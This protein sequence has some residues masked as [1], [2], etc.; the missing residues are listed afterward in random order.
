MRLVRALLSFAS[1]FVCAAKSLIADS[2]SCGGGGEGGKG[3]ESERRMYIYVR[4][5]R[6]E[7]KWYAEQVCYL[8]KLV[9]IESSDHLGNRIAQVSMPWRDI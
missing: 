7:F 9:F 2:R 6:K 5:W 1:I 8:V 3:E 4:V